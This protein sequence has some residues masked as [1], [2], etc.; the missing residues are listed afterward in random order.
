MDN[1]NLKNNFK[2]L[3]KIKIFSINVNSIIAN[4]RRATLTKFLHETRPDIVCINETK[5]N[6][7]HFLSFKKFNIIRSDNTKKERAGGTAIIIRNNLKYEHIKIPDLENNKV[8]Q[9]TILKLTLQYNKYL[10]MQM[11][12]IPLNSF[13]S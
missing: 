10:F 7:K 11:K 1:L 9:T 6:A 8:L 12:K 2:K 4:Q 5:L 13:Q 3:D